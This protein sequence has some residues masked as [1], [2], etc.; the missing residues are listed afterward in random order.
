MIDHDGTLAAQIQAEADAIL[1]VVAPDEC[2]AW[3]PPLVIPFAALGVD[4]DLEILGFS[5]PGLDVFAAWRF[6]DETLRGRPVFGFNAKRIADNART[7]AEAMERARDIAIHELAHSCIRYSPDTVD[8]LDG[9][10][11]RVVAVFKSS[12]H[13]PFSRALHG[14]AW[15]RRYSTLVGRALAMAPAMAP[16]REYVSSAQAYGY[17]AVDPNEWIAAVWMTPDYMV[18]PIAEVATRPAPRFDKLLAKVVPASTT[19]T[20]VAAYSS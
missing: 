16:A 2:P 19:A 6:D 11:T 13:V 5:S 1:R 20:A 8:D 9:F 3:S 18:G 17:G 14:P 10:I 15:W 4:D 7:E 12:D